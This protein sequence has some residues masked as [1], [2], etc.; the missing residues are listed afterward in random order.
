MGTPGIIWN[1]NYIIKGKTVLKTVL[2]CIVLLLKTRMSVPTADVARSGDDA[3]RHGN[4]NNRNNNRI[5]NCH[6]S[7][8]QGK[9]NA[10]R[11]APFSGRT[12]ALSGPVFDLSYNR[13]SK[14]LTTIDEIKTYVQANCT[15][16]TPGLMAGFNSLELAMPRQPANPVLIQ[17]D[18]ENPVRIKLWEIELN[19]LSD[20]NRVYTDFLA[21]LY[22]I[23]YGQ[24]TKDLQE[25]V[26]SHADFQA[27]QNNGFLLLR[28]IKSNVFSYDDDRNSADAVCD[29]MEKFFKMKQTLLVLS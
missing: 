2:L 16:Y 6:G 17:D 20:K 1:S 27:A 12:E 23:V 4:N 7:G 24:C 11:S 3:I 18:L 22:S 10:N 25:R 13:Q 26:M 21:N 9:Q 8:N 5:F 19:E 14:Y 28:I 15:K 29:I